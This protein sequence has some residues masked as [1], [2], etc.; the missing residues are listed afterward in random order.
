[1]YFIGPAIRTMKPEIRRLRVDDAVG[2]HVIDSLD[3]NSARLD[4]IGDLAGVVRPLLKWETQFCP[5]GNEVPEETRPSET[6]S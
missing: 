6:N 3:G 5:N 1:M 4:F 2:F